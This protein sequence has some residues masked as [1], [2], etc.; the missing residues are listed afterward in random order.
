[1]NPTIIFFWKFV[2]HWTKK[3]IKTF[4]KPSAGRIIIGTLSDITRTRTDLIAENAFLRQQL[5][6]IHRQIKRP[7]L[8]NR[9]RL[10]LVLLARCTQFWKQAVFIIQPGTLL[11]WHRDL[12]RF[13]WRWKSKPKKRKPRISLETID[14]IKKMAE[15]NRLWGAERIRG[16]LLKLGIRVSKRTIQRYLPKDRKKSGQTWATF[17]KN[18]SRDIWACDFTMAHDMLF[19][20]I[21]IF[22]ILELRKRQIVHTSVTTTPTDEWT[23]Q[24]LREATPWNTGPKYLIRDR[25]SKYGKQFSSVAVGAGIKELKTPYQAPKANAFCERFMGSLKRE[26]LD[27]M[28]ILGQR[29]C[30]HVVKEYVFYYNHARPHQGINQS[31]PCQEDQGEI[32]TNSGRVKAKPVLNGLHHDYSQASQL[33]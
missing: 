5:I 23:S 14:L 22:V 30:K 7:Q 2:F 18:H 19:R 21:Y 11:R 13:Y 3:H 32:Q 33:H 29:Q 10:S 8:T 31:I 6:I 28:L 24:Q 16:E 27:H 15:Q 25:D 20:P 9:Y 4:T 17:I 12:F 26:C 1:M